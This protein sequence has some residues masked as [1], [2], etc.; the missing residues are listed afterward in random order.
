MD[1]DPRSPEQIKYDQEQE[2]NWK[3][4]IRIPMP[5]MANPELTLADKVVYG[6]AFSFTHLFESPTQ[7]AKALGISADQVRKSK[8]KL[9]KLGLLKLLNETA[10]GKDYEAVEKFTPLV[11]K[12]KG[13]GKFH[14]P[15]GKISQPPYENFTTENKERLKGEE[16][17]ESLKDKSFKEAMPSL[18][19][20][21]EGPL[22]D[23]PEAPKRYGNADV[24][25]ILD[26]WLEETGFDHRS[27]K[28]ERFAANTL[29]RKYGCE[30]TKALIRRVG[31][32]RRSDDQ[33]APQIAKPSQLVGKYE[34]LTALKLWEDRTAKAK[35]A[36]E[37]SDEYANYCRSMYFSGRNSQPS[38]DIRPSTPEEKAE[39]HR[40]AMEIRA[41]LPF[42]VPKD[43]R[44]VD[45]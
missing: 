30:A 40:K 28:Q 12:A 36:E 41:K 5:V 18:E 21:E 13:L 29:L 8:R 34:K 19:D 15:L 27:T 31:V 3:L 9:E 4:Y 2:K 35:A 45:F 17:R 1:Q 39:V 32:A 24:N 43:Q 22:N 7:T 20:L 25:E 44:K 26:L 6:R 38:V 10:F 23:E 42:Y 11:E 37:P 16:K 33:F 14:N